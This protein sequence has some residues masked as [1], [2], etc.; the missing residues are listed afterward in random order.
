MVGS[1][2]QQLPPV[3]P[4]SENSWAP[5][6]ALPTVEIVNPILGYA[7][8]AAMNT[9]FYQVLPLLASNL[10][11][12]SLVSLCQASR[13]L[14]AECLDLSDQQLQAIVQQS[15]KQKHPKKHAW[16]RRNRVD[17]CCSS[18]A[19][20]LGALS[21]RWGIMQLAARL[22]L[23]QALLSAEGDSMACYILVRAGAR[24]TRALIRNSMA[25][26]PQAWVNA[27]RLVRLSWGLPTILVPFVTGAVEI[28]MLD[29]LQDVDS[30]LLF[31]LA[32]AAYKVNSV[33]PAEGILQYQHL[34]PQREGWSSEQVFEL[35]LLAMEQ[36][37]LRMLPA[38]LRLPAAP[39]I[40][41]QQYADLLILLLTSPYTVWTEEIGTVIM[42]RVQSDQQLVDRLAAA[43]KSASDRYSCRSY[44][45]CSVCTVMQMLPQSA[46]DLPSQLLTGLLSATKSHEEAGSAI[47][48][49]LAAS[50]GIVGAA[51]AMAAVAA[52]IWCLGRLP[53]KGEYRHASEQLLQQPVVQQLP[54]AEVQQLLLQA[55]RGSSREGLQC[56]LKGLPAVQEITG[57]GLQ[58]LLV[59]AVEGTGSSEAI[60]SYGPSKLVAKLLGSRLPVLQQL[61]PGELQLPM[62]KCFPRDDYRALQYLVEPLRATAKKL[63]HAAI[64]ELMLQAA[65][66]QASACLLVLLKLVQPLDTPLAVLQQVLPVLMSCSCVKCAVTP[67]K[68]AKYDMYTAG[69]TCTVCSLLKGAAGKLAAAD[70][71]EV[72]VAAAK[73]PVKDLHLEGFASLPGVDELEDVQVEQLL[74]AAIE[75][76]PVGKLECKG[77]QSLLSKLEQLQGELLF[78]RRLTSSAAVHRLMVACVGRAVEGGVGRLREELGLQGEGWEGL[79]TSEQLKQLVAVAVKCSSGSLSAGWVAGG[80][81]IECRPC[82]LVLAKL[83][84]SFSEKQHV[85]EGLLAA[86][87]ELL[88]YFSSDSED[89]T[90]DG[91]ESY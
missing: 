74:L 6:A 25:R 37:S 29:H 7:V 57:E 5:P 64:Y 67:T 78:S 15:L 62:M 16:T 59:A 48:V 8:G 54:L 49:A 76:L 83:L 55:V 89:G 2:T 11:L 22:D 53:W 46:A 42:L 47:L 12:T 28:P 70:V 36:Q 20:L 65:A 66:S 35:A 24:V 33:A 30:E 61:G 13:Q 77:K 27:Y 81:T 60:D 71:W 17:I 90:N 58:Q 87:R 50:R 80:H 73:A 10:D 86:G 75:A 3:H 14:H 52:G 68:V 63:P 88:L 9:H 45:C 23:Q 82:L 41:K 40:T 91:S 56:L 18:L 79:L 72:L 21:K 34:Q 44:G 85:A 38:L 19:W 69:C 26:A 31:E 43:I 84:P 1:A 32:A 51:D 4:P 39:L